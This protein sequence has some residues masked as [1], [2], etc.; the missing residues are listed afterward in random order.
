LDVLAAKGNKL[1]TRKSKKSMLKVVT[2]ADG[3]L[4]Y[5]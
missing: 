3:Q 4:Q 2:S 1:V 5:I